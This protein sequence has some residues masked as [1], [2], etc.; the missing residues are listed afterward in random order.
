MHLPDLSPGPIHLHT[1]LSLHRDLSNS[2]TLSDIT[3]HCHT[4]VTGLWTSSKIGHNIAQEH[5]TQAEAKP[6]CTLRIPD[7]SCS[8][9]VI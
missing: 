1:S 4:S 5:S 6:I 8:R 7:F 2:V 3:R 9:L